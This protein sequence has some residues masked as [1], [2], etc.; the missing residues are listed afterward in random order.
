MN[1][2][3]NEYLIAEYPNLYQGCSLS[4]E[5]S[6]MAF[7]FECDDGWFDIIKDLSAKLEPMGVVA[8]Q[9][10][11]KYGTLRFYVTMATDEAFDLIDAAEEKSA[12]TCE[13][14]GLPGELTGKGWVKTLCEA[15]EK[16]DHDQVQKR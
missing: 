10:K 13:L 16:V 4:P 1:R 12:T 3:N 11:E 5:Q 6:N 14:C 15:C 7:G 2:Q 9:V 8:S